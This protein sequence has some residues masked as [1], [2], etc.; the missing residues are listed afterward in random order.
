MATERRANTAGVNVDVKSS[1]GS[2]RPVYVRTPSPSYLV[3]FTKKRVQ[4]R[5]ISVSALENRK[6]NHGC[7]NRRLGVYYGKV[8]DQT[9][10]DGDA[11]KQPDAA[12][13]PS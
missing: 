5:R 13:A 2:G 11:E 1:L 4:P 6:S 10:V 9:Q 3:V 8:K 12:D 7:V